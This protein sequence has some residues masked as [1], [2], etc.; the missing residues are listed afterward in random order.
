[1]T[2]L[3]THTHEWNKCPCFTW[4]IV[5]FD[6]CEQTYLYSDYEILSDAEIRTSLQWGHNGG[7]GVSN[8]QPHD[9]LLNRLFRRRSK[10]K[11]KLRVTGLCGGNSPGTGDFPAQRASNEENVS[12]W[13]RHHD[14]NQT[15]PTP[16]LIMCIVGSSGH[17]EPWNW[18]SMINES[19]FCMWRYLD[20]RHH[21]CVEKR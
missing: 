21:M 17:Q 6:Q 3:L 11:S 19:L 9:C 16:W 15:W 14:P 18:I 4:G 5:N 8:H 1:M 2:P 10:K 12:I 20:M 13:W 7:D